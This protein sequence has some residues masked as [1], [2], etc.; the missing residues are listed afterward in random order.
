MGI[1]LLSVF[2]YIGGPTTVVRSSQPG[3]FY[4]PQMGGSVCK[5]D[6]SVS[7]GRRAIQSMGWF[8]R[9]DQ[10]SDKIENCVSPRAK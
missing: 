1:R 9:P 3:D 6:S 7:A 2:T 4:R 10:P 8:C 5:L